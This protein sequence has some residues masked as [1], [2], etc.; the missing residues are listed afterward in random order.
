M[1]A[2]L[3]TREEAETLKEALVERGELRFPLGQLVGSFL[4]G[5]V[6]GIKKRKAPFKPKLLNKVVAMLSE[7]Y[8]NVLAFILWVGP[9]NVDVWDASEVKE[10]KHYFYVKLKHNKALKCA[11][12]GPDAASLRR[13]T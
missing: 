13:L 4:S 1:P 9:E 7:G 8:A 12:A 11:P 6:Y 3:I 10:G 2:K 5:T